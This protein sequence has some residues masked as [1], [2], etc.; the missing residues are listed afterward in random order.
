MESFKDD[1]PTPSYDISTVLKTPHLAHKLDTVRTAVQCSLRLK[2]EV[3]KV[4]ALTGSSQTHRQPCLVSLCSF[5]SMDL[6]IKCLTPHPGRAR[7]IEFSYFLDYAGKKLGIKATKAFVITKILERQS[8]LSQVLGKLR[9]NSAKLSRF[10]LFGLDTISSGDIILL[11]R[12]IPQADG[13]PQAQQTNFDFGCIRSSIPLLQDQFIRTVIESEEENRESSHLLAA[14]PII[15]GFKIMC[16]LGKGGIRGY[17][18][19]AQDDRNFEV[20]L[21]EYLPDRILGTRELS[22]SLNRQRHC[23]LEHPNILPIRDFFVTEISNQAASCWSVQEFFELRS[24]LDEVEALAA[25]DNENGKGHSG[26]ESAPT[27]DVGLNIPQVYRHMIQALHGL[28]FLHD[29]LQLVHGSVKLSNMILKPSP[30]GHIILKLAHI[31]TG[32]VFPPSCKAATRYRSP[33]SLESGKTSREDDMFAVGCCIAAMVTGI[34]DR[35]KGI[36]GHFGNN[37]ALIQVA[38]C[39]P[40][41][42]RI[43]FSISPHTY[44]C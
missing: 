33:E 21:K 36:K 34:V 30:E 8:D 12:E 4:N 3:Q 24:V 26:L 43:S 20:V 19:L 28:Q 37:T 27:C 16:R 2:L 17:S 11:E 40:R 39:V 18:F 1:N 29:E 9:F 35:E 15:D 7:D 41:N 31:H 23:M 13:E 32:D 14:L 44:L 5:E 42:D 22:A 25:R 6:T 10:Q 38:A